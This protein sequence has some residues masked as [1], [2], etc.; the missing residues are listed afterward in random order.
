MWY[1]SWKKINESKARG[2]KGS[3]KLLN[4]LNIEI[5]VERVAYS[6]NSQSGLIIDEGSYRDGED[7]PGVSFSFL[8]NLVKYIT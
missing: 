6:G 3:L 5:K 7:L 2:K 4:L 8:T 1:E